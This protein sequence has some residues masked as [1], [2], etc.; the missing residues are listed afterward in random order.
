MI[1][2]LRTPIIFI[3]AQIKGYVLDLAMLRA[4]ATIVCQT[5]LPNLPALPAIEIAFA[6]TNSIIV[7]R[8]KK[9]SLDH[10]LNYFNSKYPIL[11]SQYSMFNN[12]LKI[13]PWSLKYP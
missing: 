12:Q 6:P 1:G 7:N 5:N 13:S 10:H 2:T 8:S 11:D 4:D 9:P 3:C